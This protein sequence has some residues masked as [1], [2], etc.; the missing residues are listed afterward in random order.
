MGR[1][2]IK[3][4]IRRIRL[5]IADGRGQLKGKNYKSGIYTYE[6]PSKGKTARV[7]GY[8]TKRI[9]H[10]LSQIEKNYLVLLDYDPEVTEILDQ[11]FLSLEDTLLIAAEMHIRHPEADG[12]PA[13]MSTD[14]V[15]CRNGQWYATAIKSSQDI[16]KER[17][18]QKLRIEEAYWKKKGIPWTLVTEKDIPMCKVNNLRWLYLGE[19]SVDSLIP[20]TN[21]RQSIIAGF[22]E[23]YGDYSIPFNEI[24]ETMESYYHLHSGT[25]LQLFKWL[26]REKRIILDLSVPIDPNEPRSLMCL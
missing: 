21:Q 19:L 23:L 8:T 6:I 3:N 14:F 2:R 13:Q 20:K 25:M 11:A 1:R 9:H 10:C 7:R 24:T 15:Y 12:V 22:L 17:T 18:L 4:T 16:K 5:R 26:V